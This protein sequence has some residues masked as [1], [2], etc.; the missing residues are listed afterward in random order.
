MPKDF[1]ENFLLYFRFVC[2]PTYLLNALLKRLL[3]G[4]LTILFLDLNLDL[5]LN[6][7]QMQSQKGCAS[8][9]D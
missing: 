3:Y 9:S 7:I 2:S 5:I 6:F 4:L 1:I 8:R